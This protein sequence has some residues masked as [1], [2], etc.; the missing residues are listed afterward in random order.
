MVITNILFFD[1]TYTK[2][3]H[4]LPLLSKYS[5]ASS[6]NLYIII[7]PPYTV[8]VQPLAVAIDVSHVLAPVQPVILIILSVK[9]GKAVNI[10]FNCS[11]VS[12]LY[13]MSICG[14]IP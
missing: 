11:A 5:P 2:I 10:V 14:E 7:K 6:N 1:L 4:L 9:V 12:V 8:T 13:L 3:F